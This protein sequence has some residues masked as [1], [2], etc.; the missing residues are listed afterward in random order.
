MAAWRADGSMLAVWRSLL[1]PMVNKG[2][3]LQE[4]LLQNLRA[5]H[6]ARGRWVVILSQGGHFAAA[7]FDCAPAPPHGQQSKKDALLFSAVEH[8]TF[9]RYVVR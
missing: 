8:K 7:V 9:H 1:E 4:Q 6:S 3:L 5:L 2:R